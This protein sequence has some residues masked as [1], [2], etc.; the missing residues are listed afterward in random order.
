MHQQR[1]EELA[2]SWPSHRPAAE[3]ADQV[4]AGPRS[5]PTCTSGSP[6]PASP[7]PRVA[8]G[9]GHVV[10]APPGLPCPLDLEPS[11]PQGS[12]SLCLEGSPRSPAPLAG[13]CRRSVRMPRRALGPSPACPDSPQR[14]RSPFPLS[15]PPHL[16]PLRLQPSL[17]ATHAILGKPPS[18]FTKPCPDCTPGPSSRENY[19]VP[20]DR[21]TSRPQ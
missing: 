13:S 17:L 20:A 14:L 1:L 9:H 3:P 16:S 5:C 15:A 21:S 8:T 4:A 7:S 18:G 19:R 6:E 2:L 10:L 11:R 12:I